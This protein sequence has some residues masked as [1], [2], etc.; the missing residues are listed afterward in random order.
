MGIDLLNKMK[1]SLKKI[2]KKDNINILS[3]FETLTNDEIAMVLALRA[4]RLRLKQ[5]L[6]QKKFS[7]NLE[8]SSATTYCNFEQKGTIS[9]INFIKIIREFGLLEELEEIFKPKDLKDI[10]EIHEKKDSNNKRVSKNKKV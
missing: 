1:L 5:E 6:S 7:E 2:K 3:N 8:L 9:L 4:K 10:L